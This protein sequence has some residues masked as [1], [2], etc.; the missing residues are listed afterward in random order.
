MIML[1]PMALPAATYAYAAGHPTSLSFS[2][3]NST[4]N[5][6]SSTVAT[7]TTASTST[8]Y[9][10]STTSVASSS[11][12]YPTST[13]AST[14]VTTSTI[15]TTSTSSTV[16]TSTTY[17]TYTTSTS[18]IS[19]TTIRANTTSTIPANT[20][21]TTSTTTIPPTSTTYHTSTSS[22][23][24]T[25]IPTNTMHTTST[26]TTIPASTTYSTSTSSISST[27][28][29]A[30]T[31][32]VIPTNTVHTTS[33]TSL[34]STIPTTIYSNSV[35]APYN[36]SI[37]SLTAN[38]PL[39]GNATIRA[40]W[41]GSPSQYTMYVYSGPSTSCSSDTNL[42]TYH[43]YTA[44]SAYYVSAHPTASS[45]YCYKLVDSAGDYAYSQ[46]IYI[47]VTNPGTVTTMPSTT[48][49]YANAI[50]NHTTSTSSTI[51]STTTIYTNT[52]NRTSSSTSYTT[53]ISSNVAAT[54]PIPLSNLTISMVAG[55]TATSTG[56][57]ATIRAS[58]SG[59]AK[60]FGMYVFSG[61]SATCA[62]DTRPVSYYNITAPPAYVSVYPNAS[63]YYCYRLADS[64]GSSAYS[65]TQYINVPYICAPPS[66]YNATTMSCWSPSVVISTRNSSQS[67]L[68]NISSS[69][70]ISANALLALSTTS[71]SLI[72][73]C[74][75]CAG[76]TN[77][78]QG[79][80]TISASSNSTSFA[81]ALSTN[82]ILLNR[83]VGNSTPE[84][85]SIINSTI[86]ANQT[87]GTANSV[88]INWS[89]SGAAGSRNVSI[90]SIKRT[91]T[92]QSS[93]TSS[94]LGAQYV[95][96]YMSNATN[97]SV[98]SHTEVRASAVIRG[99]SS[100]TQYVPSNVTVYS[101]RGNAA[102]IS[103]TNLVRNSSNYVNTTSASRL[104]L[105]SVAITSRKN[106]TTLAAGITV[107]NSISSANAV[108]SSIV[109]RTNAGNVIG[110]IVI[111]SSVNDSL[112]KTV[113]YRFNVSK[114]LL[115][116][117][118]ISPQSVH[119]YRQNATAAKW[120]ALPTNLTGSNAT[121]YFYAA[122][123]P[124]MS[125]Y[126]IGFG[127]LESNI[128]QTN[129]TNLLPTQTSQKKIFDPLFM[130][131]VLLLV[132][133]AAIVYLALFRRGGSNFPPES[134]APQQYDPSKT[135]EDAINNYIDQESR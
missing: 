82:S 37:T 45:Y 57:S 25:T 50:T 40:S 96:N 79:I 55:V 120:A 48:T 10:T 68:K 26:T 98:T 83:F 49:I 110:I 121:Q 73:K 41:S 54:P 114:R 21:Q 42:V 111:N 14:S 99:N 65:P 103:I 32:S 6:A 51:S 20:F 102:V 105:D 93:I 61:S 38:V 100:T 30:N 116:M 12:T 3:S 22:I 81:N 97:I 60:P 125:I 109:H 92:N 39:G 124:G 28:V 1:L 2:G 119:L 117:K 43:S 11:T 107:Y 104:S 34:T 64:A 66:T 80:T 35:I 36:L 129:S 67:S 74:A 101:S 112:I 8:V 24:S 87:N 53:T 85:F 118:S 88:T 72:I 71:N 94:E 134:A 63:T 29:H 86:T 70:G 19:S 56:G 84:G 126:A 47:Y 108:P 18:S 122:T 75:G 44:A 62:S 127:Y 106:I 9:S 52:I 17:T 78:T 77:N 69:V 128:T 135:T 15:H 123:S 76:A 89:S 90:D 95:L 31:T 130:L 23:S 4:N 33:T 133:A 59:N 131:V 13:T 132:I 58:W 5:T 7:T 46:T 115:A 91:T 113:Q 16:P 27:T